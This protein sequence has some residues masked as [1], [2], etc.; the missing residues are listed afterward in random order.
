MKRNIL[1]Q[2]IFQLILLL[3]L[4]YNGAQM[5][6]VTEGISCFEYNVSSKNAKWDLSTKKRDDVSGTF[7]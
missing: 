4:L 6:G 2:A 7:S 5:F 3:V 1:V